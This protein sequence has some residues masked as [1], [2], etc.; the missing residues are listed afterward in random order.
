MKDNVQLQ[1]QQQQHERELQ[2]LKQQHERELQTLKQQHERELQTLKQ[3]NDLLQR[4]NREFQSQ[5]FEI[6][7]QP[8]QINNTTNQNQTHTNN[9]NTTI[10]NQLAIYDLTQD[11]ITQLL[12]EH[13]NLD[14][15][16]GGP[17]EIAKLTARF[18]LTDP[19]TQ[20]PKVTCTDISRKNF[21]YV[22][23]EQEVQV[24]PGFQRT[25]DLIKEP[26]SKANIRVYVDEL[27]ND[28]RYHDQ[29]RKNEDFISNRTGFSDK[30]VKWM[31]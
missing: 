12:N 24:D 10:V 9:R 5:I 6:A 21:R 2:T 25:H 13:Y 26:L 11:Q 29:W 22:D 18:L 8:K 7:K 23:E 30:L 17:E 27:H 19:Q 31:I 28:D 20:K 1:M 14:T 15:F 3:Q 16:H 4:Q